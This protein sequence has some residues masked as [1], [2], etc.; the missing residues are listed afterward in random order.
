MNVY[1]FVGMAFERF[2]VLYF[3]FKARRHITLRKMQMVSVAIWVTGLV[4]T[5]L[6]LVVGIN[7]NS[8]QE[9]TY[10]RF[11]DNLV[12]KYFVLFRRIIPLFGC[13]TITLIL[14]VC[15]GILVYRRYRRN[16]GESKQRS[17]K[18]Q[19]KTYNNVYIYDSG[20]STYKSFRRAPPPT[21]PNSFIFTYHFTEKCLCRRL[22][23]P[24]MRV[25]TPPTGNPGSAPV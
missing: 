11:S 2:F 21:G 24:P 13:S 22:A 8:P 20:G 3:P 6:L 9:L 25:G 10:R 19:L 18:H 16:I 23:P 15:T 7:P 1:T 12:D 14:Y 17:S 4:S 5:L